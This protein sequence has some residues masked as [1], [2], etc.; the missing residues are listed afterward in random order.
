MDNDNTETFLLGV[1][2]C[3]V[4]SGVFFAGG[5]KKTLIVCCGIAS[6]LIPSGIRVLVILVLTLVAVEVVVP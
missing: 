1:V 4:R 2:L 3:C 5:T 6:L